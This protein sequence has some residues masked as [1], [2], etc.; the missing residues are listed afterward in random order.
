MAAS[1]DVINKRLF[2]HL[3]YVQG[4]LIQL[5]FSVVEDCN[6]VYLDEHT[7]VGTAEEPFEGGVGFDFTFTESEEIANAWVATL[8]TTG[9]AAQTL[10]YEV[11]MDSSTLLYGTLEIKPTRL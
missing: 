9:I 3:S 7:L 2:L 6:Q 1:N 4:E 10:N 8:D 11:R 5:P